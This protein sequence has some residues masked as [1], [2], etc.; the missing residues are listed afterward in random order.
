MH[1]ATVIDLP[2]VMHHVMET[3]QE[4]TRR[5]MAID[6][7]ATHLATAI[8]REPTHPAMVMPQSGIAPEMVKGGT[9]TRPE[10]GSPRSHEQVGRNERSA[11]PATHSHAE[12]VPEL[13]R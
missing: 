10:T 1:P 5:V 3:D 11:V 4:R 13:R 2:V 6:H 8:D 12:S 9:E 7:A